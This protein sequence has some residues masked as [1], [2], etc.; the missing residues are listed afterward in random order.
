MTPYRS[1]GLAALLASTILST[2][3]LAFAQSDAPQPDA[4]ASVDEEATVDD[5][6]V[7]G[8]FVP[9]VKRET[10]EVANILTAE[11]IERSGDSEIGEALTRVTGLSLVGDGFVYV[12][13]LGDRYSSALLDGSSLP[14][15]EPLRRVVPLDLFP[16]A[17][18]NGALIQK[19]YSAE[20][21]GDFGGGVIALSTR[22]IPSERFFQFGASIGAN[23]ETLGEDGLYWDAGG[24]LANIGYGDESLRLPQFLRTDPSLEAFQGDPNLLQAA[25]RSLRNIWSIDGQ[26]NLPDF[27]F[28]ISG[29]EIVD[30]SN[31][32]RI[33]AYVGI[34]YGYEVRNREGVRGSYDVNGATNE[35][36]APEAC[37]NFNGLDN[38]VNCGFRR[39]DQEYALNGLVSLGLELNEDHELKLTS[40][41]LRKTRQQTLIERGV[42][43]SDPSLLRSFQRLNWVEQQ[44]FTNQLTGKHVFMLPMALDRL[45][46]DW[47][48]AYSTASRDTPYRREYTY[49]LEPDDV[50]RLT[51]NSDSNRTIFT[52]L[53]DE[54]VEFGG[55]LTLDG[56]IADHDL[57]IKVGALYQEKTRDFATRRYSFIAAPGVIVP[58]ELREY[59]PEIIFSPDNIG[60]NAGYVLNDVTD[61]SD[62]FDGKTTI[63]AAYISVEG[64]ITP[65]I[66]LSVG[67]RY[68]DSQQEVNTFTP[69]TGEDVN[70]DL[71]AEYFLPAATLTWEFADNMQFRIGYSQTINRPDLRELANA[72]FLDDDTGTLE[73]GNPNLQIA[74]IENFDARW[75]WYFGDRQ[76]ATIGV[77]Y[78]TF[79]NPI[80]RTF[81]PVGD[82]FGR[83][84]QNADEATLQG[85]EAEIDYTLPLDEWFASSDFMATRRW[86][87]I[88]NVT[89]SD[90]EVIDETF[91]RRLQGQSEWLGNLQIGF[92]NPD[93][94]QRATL[95]LNYQGERISDAGIITGVTR[96]PDVIE[97]PPL[98]LDFTATQGFSVMGR[99]LDL[100]FKVENILGEEFERSQSFANG[101]EGVVESYKLGTTIS[102]G[103]TARF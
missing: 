38:A 18:V 72:L 39:T 67:G 81:Q 65:D 88:A 77:F 19:T 43:A 57:T 85:V 99:E 29:A 101:S 75:E 45:Q 31:G 23:S 8:R 15:P 103:L 10:S 59:V 70:V 1:V 4:A 82:G 90:S 28:N 56:A 87:V 46:F 62:F 2:P 36:I 68:E 9:D 5:I 79:T 86:F 41:L 60:G 42:F 47:R 12:R 92:E 49:R 69:L 11:D 98:M 21:P 53:E 52:A 51:P 95:L 76:S 24:K 30:F 25:G 96:L 32:A 66:R 61:P 84:F 34:D 37:E 78:K 44:L 93:V 58:A 64:A 97:T 55:D 94:R 50:F 100:G 91:T 74:E 17:L 27:G 33:G 63:N 35:L 20:Y 71:N 7:R 89:Y 83:S 40:L 48:A 102:V 80:E 16:T 73:L 6:I 26:D 3:A 13:G 14:S 22:A 54:N